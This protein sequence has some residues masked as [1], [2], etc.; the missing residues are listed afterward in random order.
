[1]ET[2]IILRTHK[3]KKHF[4][5]VHA[6]DGVSISVS[7][8]QVYGFL[9]PNGSGKTTTIGM[10]L[11]LLHPTAGSIT[12]FADPLTPSRNKS[13][14]RV[15]ALVGFAS[16]VPYLSARTYLPSYPCCCPLIC[17]ERYQPRRAGGSGSQGSQG[18]SGAASACRRSSDPGGPGQ[19][20]RGPQPFY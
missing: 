3:L 1:M 9:G 8:G 11:G 2:D 13:L 14:Q 18:R 19:Q 17:I 16:L 4:G 15:G 10:I 5:Q 12:I 6:V 20:Q 7:R